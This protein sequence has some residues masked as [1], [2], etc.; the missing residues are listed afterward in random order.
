[1]VSD[2]RVFGDDVTEV[3]DVTGVDDVTELEDVTPSSE[4]SGVDDVTGVDEVTGVD[5]VTEVDDVT[6]SSERSRVDVA[7]IR[8]RDESSRKWLDGVDVDADD[9]AVEDL[10]TVE[11][12]AE[13]G[14]VEGVD[15][16]ELVTTVLGTTELGLVVEGLVVAVLVAT[17]VTSSDPPF[18]P[19]DPLDPLSAKA[20]PLSSTTPVTVA[21]NV[22]R[23]DSNRRLVGRTRGLVDIWTPS[24]RNCRTGPT[25]C[26]GAG[27]EK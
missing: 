15:T 18:R 1:M 3:E 9:V 4:C 23:V 10:E 24:G 26:P 6:P 21:A 16:T 13:D 2:F 22:A 14:G 25:Q 12:D 11:V 20:V 19:D 27:V 17:D 8:S 7:S 5:D